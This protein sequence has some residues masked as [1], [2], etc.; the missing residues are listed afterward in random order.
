MPG[1][2]GIQEVS[3]HD[4]VKLLPVMKTQMTMR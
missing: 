1:D 4:G 2:D 3:V